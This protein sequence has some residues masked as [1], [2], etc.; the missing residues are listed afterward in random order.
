MFAGDVGRAFDDGLHNSRS[1]ARSRIEMAT[2][3][4]LALWRRTYEEL[5]ESMVKS[6]EQ[7]MAS[8]EEVALVEAQNQTVEFLGCLLE[9][10]QDLQRYGEVLKKLPKTEDLSDEELEKNGRQ[11]RPAVRRC[12]GSYRVADQPSAQG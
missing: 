12:S 3:D 7:F 2:P 9:I 8:S 1:A 4:Q 11:G 10:K 5:H 6:R